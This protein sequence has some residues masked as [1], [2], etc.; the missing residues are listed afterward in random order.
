MRI[1]IAHNFYRSSAPSGEDAV[2][3]NEKQLLQAHGHEVVCFERHNDD[4]NDATVLSKLSVA[5]SATWSRESYRSFSK[6]I[7]ETKPD[8]AHFH[9]TFP[10][11]SPSAYAACHDHG[12]AVVQTLH[13]YRLICPGALLQRNGIPCEDCIGKAPLRGILHRCY[14]GSF[15]SSAAVAAIIIRNRANGTYMSAVDRYI[16]LT[17][18]SKGRMIAGG[19]P[20][21]KIAVKCNFLPTPPKPGNGNGGYAVYVGRLSEEKGVL[22]L[23]RAWRSLPDVKLK[24]AGDGPLRRR[25]EQ[26]IINDKL[27]VELL[28][29][30]TRDEILGLLGNALFQVVPSEWYEGFP[31]V[32]LEAFAC[33]TPVI[34][35][36]IGS[37][38]EIVDND[39]SG[40][41]F[42]PGDSDSLVS[43]IRKLLSHEDITGTLRESVRNLFEKNYTSKQNIIH[44]ERIYSDATENRARQAFKLRESSL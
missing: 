39:I 36:D 2:Y 9:N 4:L 40:Y 1:L 12:V 43:A 27:N 31:M 35:S 17:E 29:Y 37:L 18:F 5:L 14:R 22:T 38:S 26:T 28:G 41:K 34:A 24:I 21:E 33:G 6:C 25:I 42:T 15:L 8:I 7:K 13:N 32:L 10:L 23:L 3:H 20:P 19:L 30:C 44:L 16:A 11:I